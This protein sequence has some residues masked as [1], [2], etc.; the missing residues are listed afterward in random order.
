MIVAFIGNDGCGKTTI[1]KKFNY[2]LAEKGYKVSMISEFDYFVL[3]IF[4]KIFPAL[5]KKAKEDIEF[6]NKRN[7]IKKMMPYFIWFDLLA[8]YYYRNIF[9]YK[10]IVIKDRY[11]YDFLLTWREQNISNRVIE[12][13]YRNLPRPDLLFFIFVDP[14]IAYERRIKQKGHNFTKSSDFYRKKTEEYLGLCKSNKVVIEINNNAEIARSVSEVIWYLETKI[15]FTGIRSIAI[16]GLDGAGKTTTVALL[17]DFL[18]KINVE[19]IDVHF[20]Y[21]YIIVKLFKRFI[22]LKQTTKEVKYKNSIKNEK[23]AIKKGKSRFWT[24]LV[25]TDA[26][27][28]YLYFKITSFNKL[29]IFDRFFQDYIISFHYINASYDQDRLLQ[30]FPKVNR[31]FLQTAEYEVLHQRKPEHTI[32]F[33]KFCFD[34]YQELSK[35]ERLIIL[36]SSKDNPNEILKKLINEI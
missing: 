6:D 13:L 11:A 18:Y 3:R 16:S 23:K 24:W 7:L 26:M 10:T 2:F 14:S 27:I 30:L 20:Y 33:F 22:N 32:S 12:F 17:K 25:I 9:Q 36:D 8:E 28:Q 35:R 34:E 21:D 29:V 1:S 15:K 19:Y 5:F 31:H 4:K